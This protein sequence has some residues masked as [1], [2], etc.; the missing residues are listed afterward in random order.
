[1]LVIGGGIIG[2]EMATVYDALGRKVTVVEMLDQL[3]PGADADLVRPLHK[4]IKQ[5]YEAIM[6]GTQVTAVKAPKNGL[7]VS[8]SPRARTRRSTVSSSPSVARPNGRLLDADRAGVNVD[9]RGFIPVDRQ[10]RTNVPTSTR[11]ATSSADRCSPTRPRTR[12]RPPR[13]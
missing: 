5:R 4:R 11:S 6:L 7:Q 13:R 10:M 9:E 8:R 1:M 12:P 3:I 2:L